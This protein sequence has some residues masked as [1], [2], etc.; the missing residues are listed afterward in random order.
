MGSDL[1]QE[2]YLNSSYRVVNIIVYII[3]NFK[4]YEIN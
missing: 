1:H 3:I 2:I 4:I